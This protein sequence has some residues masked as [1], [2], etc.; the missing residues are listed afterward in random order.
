MKNIFNNFT[1]LEKTYK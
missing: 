1:Q